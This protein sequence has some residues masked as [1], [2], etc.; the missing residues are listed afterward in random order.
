MIISNTA[1]K[2][3]LMIII[4]ILLVGG[5]FFVAEYRNKQTSKIIYT[6]A[7]ISTST[8]LENYADSTDWKNILLATDKNSSSTIKDITK[9]PEELTPVDILGRDFFARYMELRQLGN[10][11]DEASQ[12]DLINQVLKNGFVTQSPKVYMETDI[13]VKEDSSVASI[14]Q[15]GN[16]L[17]S[18]L[19]TYSINSRNEAVIAKEAIEKNDSSVLKELDPILA[20]Y[21]TILNKILA[22]STP[23]LLARNHL[24]LVNL[25][26][27]SI[28]MIE[29][30]KKSMQD[31]IAGMQSVAIAV[32]N[33]EI[34]IS[35]F[36]NIR[37]NFSSL[38]ITY[39]PTEGGSILIPQ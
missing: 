26:S 11:N 29:G 20:S 23:Q 16:E 6:G 28:L 10:V 27:S 25:M 8:D 15:Y 30:F 37:R 19:K 14:K 36:E 33:S 35:I 38:G 4:A 7:I 13:I 9:K 21:K 22:I 3:V 12:Q 32:K 17:G 5:A 2:N 18:V 31:P 1:R 34:A 24:D 39:S